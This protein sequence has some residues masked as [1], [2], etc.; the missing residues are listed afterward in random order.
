MVRPGLRRKKK[1][2]KR[3]PSGKTVTRYRRP[4][5]SKHKCGVCG[6]V[7]HGTPRGRPIDIRRL[8]KSKRSPERP[9]GGQ[10]CSKC[11]RKVI[12]LRA[13]L[14]HKSIGSDAVPISLK[15]YM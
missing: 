14:K 13:K 12:A 11:S 3:L 15:R 9:F 2:Q 1:V 5:H 7:L 10:L 8:F 4:M 6:A